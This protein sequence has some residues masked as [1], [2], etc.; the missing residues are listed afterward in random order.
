MQGQTRQIPRI[1]ENFYFEGTVKC[2]VGVINGKQF[3]QQYYY[4][5]VCK[6][7]LTMLLWH[8]LAQ[9]KTKLSWPQ[10]VESGKLR[11]NIKKYA[12][13]VV[14]ALCDQHEWRVLPKNNNWYPRYCLVLHVARLTFIFTAKLISW[15]VCLQNKWACKD[16]L[17]WEQNYA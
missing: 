5:F 9:N 15:I 13:S 11:L 8:A 3:W 7:K 1:S 12:M 6:Q 10:I 4:H 17:F 2:K 14:S 16:L